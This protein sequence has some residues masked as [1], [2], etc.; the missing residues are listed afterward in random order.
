M[1]ILAVCSTIDF[2]NFV[3]RATLEEIWRQ[4]PETDFL[5]FTG[6]KNKFKAKKTIEGPRFY[7]Y[8]FWVPERFK[9]NKTLTYMEYRLRKDRWRKHFEK[10]DIIF[11]SDPN[12]YYLLEYLNEQKVVYLLRDPNI[13]LN[14]NNYAKEKAI[15]GRADMVLAISKNLKDY[16][17][18]E[19][20]RD[21]PSNVRLWSNSVD[22][23]L[24]NYENVWPFKKKES[25]PVVGLAGNLTFVNDVELL[26]YLAMKRPEYRFRIA[27]GINLEA[28]KLKMFEKTLTRKNVQ[29][30]GRIPIEEFPKEVINWTI[31][32]VAGDRA[33][34]Y[35]KYLNNN[36]QYQYL[37]LGKPF[38]TYNHNAGY[39]DFEDMVFIAKDREDFMDKI[40]LAIRRAKKSDC[41]EMG[42]RIAERNSA[43]RRA[44]EFLEYVEGIQH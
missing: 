15:L 35:S 20:Y 30:I 22:L 3:R 7:S 24:W 36:K 8:H 44:R 31:G 32:I 38:V 16:Y 5:F 18:G 25:S 33:H 39:D 40:D 42:R 34:E 14:K 37:A 28:D 23:N 21:Y 6:I 11:L 19:Y 10:Y 4:N 26:D 12:Q 13:L 43:H 9:T 41:I 2:R 1:K 29:H 17:L 27:G